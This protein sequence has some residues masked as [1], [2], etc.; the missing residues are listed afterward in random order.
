MNI[1]YVSAPGFRGGYGTYSDFV[2]VCASA[3]EA[4]LTHPVGYKLRENPENLLVEEPGGYLS[5]FWAYRLDQIQVKLIGT[6]AP[7]AQ[8]GIICASFC[9]G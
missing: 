5:S 3:E 7:D 9:A 4:A 2:V 1:Y 6:A 8:P